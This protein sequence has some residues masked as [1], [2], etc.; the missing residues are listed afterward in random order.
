MNRL[1]T[2]NRVFDLKIVLLAVC[3]LLTSCGSKQ[4]KAIEDAKQSTSAI[5]YELPMPI[6]PD[7]LRSIEAR[8]NYVAAHYWDAMDFSNRQ[9]ST[10]TAF[11]EQNFA[12]FVAILGLTEI[13]NADKAIFRLVNSVSVDTAAFSLLATTAGKYLDEPNS[14]MRN[15]ELYI[16]FLKYFIDSSITT[17]AERLRY[18]NRLTEAMKNRRGTRAA[19]FNFIDSDGVTACLSEAVGKADVTLLVFYDPDCSHCKEII[20]RIADIPLP[21][22]VDVLAIDAEGDR[23][24]WDATKSTMPAGWRV[25]FATTPILD[26]EL[27]S[28]PASPTLYLLDRDA[29]VIMKD[30]AVDEAIAFITSPTTTNIHR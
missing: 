12:N 21:A 18:D 2:I 16:Y 3:F 11:I 8:A 30:P 19:D 22:G 17:D 6:V 23:S 13:S 25:G 20:G 7:T 14:P 10:D 29:T 1:G 24:R 9:I 27:Y 4:A 28:L 15:E 5:G 26:K